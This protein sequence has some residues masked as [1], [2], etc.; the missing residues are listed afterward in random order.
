M[1]TMDKRSLL[2][3]LFKN[4]KQKRAQRVRDLLHSHWQA[5][6]NDHFLANCRFVDYKRNTVYLQVPKDRLQLITAEMARID[7]MFSALLGKD[8]YRKTVISEP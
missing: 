2:A 8:H 4:L 3:L 7:E 5:M 1:K 6:F